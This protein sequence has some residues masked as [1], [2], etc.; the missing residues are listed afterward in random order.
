[1][2]WDWPKTPLRAVYEEDLESFLKAHGLWELIQRGELTCEICGRPIVA[3][4]L[5]GFMHTADGW[6]VLCSRPACFMKAL[7]AAETS[8]AGHH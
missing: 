3:E 6:K 7:E 1:M 8:H 2:R 4:N 5:G